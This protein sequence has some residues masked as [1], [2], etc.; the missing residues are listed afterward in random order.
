MSRLTR[1]R[2]LPSVIFAVLCAG[3][4][5]AATLTVTDCGDTTPGGAAGQLRKLINDAAPG[6]TIVVPACT[7]LLT[8]A[9]SEDLN[10]G[11][12][13][14]IRI[15]LT[16]RGAGQ[17]ATIVDGGGIDRVFDVPAGVTVTLADLAVQDGGNPASG[18]AGV[19]NAGSLTLQ[20]V[21]V[22]DNQAGAFFGG[23]GIRN[24]GSL[25]AT[26]VTIQGN[27]AKSGGGLLNSAGGSV[28]LTNSA[29]S[30]NHTFG[31][32]VSDTGGGITNLGTAL[33]SN[34]TISG[35]SSA[36]AGAIY[37]DGTIVLTNVTLFANTSII[38]T[39]GLFTM[40]GT[41]T[42]G[43]TVLA[44]SGC[45]PAGVPP[46]SLGH[47]V[48]DDGSCGLAGPGDQVVADAKLGPLADNGGP[49]RTHALLSGSPAID[50][51]DNHACPVT[52]Q[53]NVLRPQNGVCDV[54]AFEIQSGFLGGVYLAAGDLDGDG[55]AEIITGAGAGS[56]PRVRTFKAD[57]T[58]AALDFYAYHLAFRGGVRVASCDVTG[59]SRAD[60]ITGAGPGGGPHVRVFDGVTGAEVT[61]FFAYAPAFTGG[62]FVACGNVLGD[63]T[64]AA[65]IITGADAGGGP[66]VRVFT[67]AGTDTG[68]GFFAY[69]PAF[70]GGVRVAACDVNGDGRADIVT[71]AGPGGGPHVRVFDGATLAEL[72]GF[73]AYDVAF[74]GGV[75]VACGDVLAG[76][77]PELVTGAD[78]GGGPH[79]RV[80][81]ATGADAGVGFFAYSAAFT[82]GVRVAV[83][84][85]D[86]DGP[87]E[88]L[89]AAGAGGGPHVRA[90]T[91]TGG[92]LPSTSFFAY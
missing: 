63:P 46:I 71:A 42:L 47:N 83:G 30:G 24:S 84:D 10:A 36:L 88:I 56:G 58:P 92:P 1:T 85:L 60:I 53:R 90:F 40:G 73:F 67:G 66:H 79:V 25:T 34:V 31:F 2:A 57:G 19:Q 18:G 49:T 5:G 65:Q 3:P 61:G 7:I 89:T 4:A 86:G 44:A 68:I 76:A 43:N 28:A 81:T 8:G 45:H 32:I 64:G 22:R 33:L 80:F 69:A 52:D 6:D 55:A 27:G 48:A 54:G 41:L 26:E 82:G 70:L 78:A 74:T 38:G 91:G 12:D 62:V 87:G 29:I 14:D 50:A 13:L 21:T 77:H 11:G 51:G 15:D 37:N 9:A 59:D 35:N 20:R 72:A 23:G 75:F 17:G 16:I 39:G